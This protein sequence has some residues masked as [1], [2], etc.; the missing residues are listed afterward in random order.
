MTFE[1][2]MVYHGSKSAICETIAV[3]E[4]RVDGSQHISLAK[5]KI[6]CLRCTLM[7]FERN[8]QAKNLS[9]QILQIRQLSSNRSLAIFSHTL[10]IQSPNANFPK[11]FS[12]LKP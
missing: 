2:L 6:M 10:A 1:R 8:Y 3:K 9:K 11:L 4:Q 7:G 12:S 5:L